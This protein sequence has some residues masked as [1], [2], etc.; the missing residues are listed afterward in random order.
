MLATVLE[1]LRAWLSTYFNRDRYPVDIV[2]IPK[3]LEENS[4][5][6][7]LLGNS[8]TGYRCYVNLRWEL[9]GQ[10]DQIENV[11]KLLAF[12]NWVQEQSAL[13]VAPRLGDIPALERISTEKGGFT[14]SQQ[15]VNYT[16]TL[17]AEFAKVYDV[18]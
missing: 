11:L 13:G 14:P 17:V 16:V 8:R 9:P 6:V 15:V 7:D 2:L 3:A 4:R 5:Q 10:G 12:Q 18:K 1:E